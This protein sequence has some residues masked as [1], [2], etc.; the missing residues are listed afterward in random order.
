M[1]ARCCILGLAACLAWAGPAAAASPTVAKH[2]IEAPEQN[3]IPA[4]AALAKA[5]P[6]GFPLGLGSGVA[7]AG[8]DA[9]G[10]VLLYALG[11]RGPNADAPDYVAAPGAKP[12]PAKIFP[13]P[14]YAPS[15]AKVK[16]KDGVVTVLSI[17]P[18]R[19]ASGKPISGRPIPPGA[20]GSTGETP[21]GADLRVLPLD[22]EG[23][24]TEGVSVSPKDGTLWLCDEY[25]PF[26][27]QV[28]PASGKVLR[29]YGP[30]QGL[31]VIVAKRQPNRGFEGVAAAKDGKVFAVV[32]SILDVDGKVKE[33]K[34]PFVRIVELDP[35]TGKTRM[36]AYPLDVTA[37][38]KTADA[39]MG[40]LAAVSPT[41]LVT[42]EQ[43]KGADKKMRNM[44]YAIDLTGA[45][46]L[47]G[48]TTRDGK[49]LET[50][51]DLDALKAL[52]VVP[53]Q[54]TLVADLRALGWNTEKAEGLAI[55]PDGKTLFL[56]SDNDFGMTIT[57]NQPATD[58]DGK[59]VTN[60]GKYQMSAD[61]TL[62]YK[63][64]AVPTTFTVT[65][66]TEKT[67]LWIMTLPEALR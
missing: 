38:K 5:F 28:D 20:V 33:S 58:K 34:A 54:K 51:A 39:K 46:D 12:A 15:L 16:I 67:E 8:R 66:T 32:Q 7:Y 31:P 13:A 56:T 11:D 55:A 53:A 29:K 59:P 30:G 63:G 60:P 9:D 49:P 36:F 45:T 21:L 57:P 14:D 22:P 2:V 25:G 48:K 65:P 23:L 24:D 18:L 26:L 41:R 10:A 35:A 19:D 6:K 17:T 61:G 62:S 43:G 40:D 42:V 52:G 1:S 37:Y 50:V 47:T 3:N 44:V 27:I 4:P 64:K